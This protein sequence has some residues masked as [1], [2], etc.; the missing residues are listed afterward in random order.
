MS[1]RLIGTDSTN[2]RLPA[3]V[4]AATQGTSAADLAPGTTLADANEYTDL[5]YEAA[6]AYADVLIAALEARVAALEEA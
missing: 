6:K 4:V 5:M 2:P 3:I 1:V